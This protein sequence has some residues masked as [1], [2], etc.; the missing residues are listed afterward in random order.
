MRNEDP[1]CKR[2]HVV[3]KDRCVLAEALEIEI[4]ILPDLCADQRNLNNSF[5]N[6]DEWKQSSYGHQDDFYDLR[7]SEGC[8]HFR[9]QFA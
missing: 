3:L 8:S 2:G 9:V 7:G 6:R 5:A 1:C 4:E